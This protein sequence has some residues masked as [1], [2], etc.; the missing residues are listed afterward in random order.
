MDLLK[1]LG[2]KERLGRREMALLKVLLNHEE[3]VVFGTFTAALEGK[4]MSRRTIAKGLKSLVELGILE[5]R[6]EIVKGRKTWVYRFRSK[7]VLEVFRR[8]NDQLYGTVKESYRLVERP[9]LSVVGRGKALIRCVDRILRYQRGLTLMAIDLAIRAPD[10]RTAAGR[11]IKLMD[12]FT[13]MTA[14]NAFAACWLNKD[15]AADVLEA[16]QLKAEA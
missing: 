5:K 13:D 9:G 1:E 10:V 6:R 15:I 11:F 7:E 16:M 14:I 8:M 12:H 4:A 2:V 3:E